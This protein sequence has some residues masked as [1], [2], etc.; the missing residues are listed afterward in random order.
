[1]QKPMAATAGRLCII[2]ARRGVWNIVALLLENGADVNAKTDDG[3]TPLV[4][5]ANS[6]HDAVGHQL[7]DNG[8]QMDLIA[9]V[10]FEN[11]EAVQQI[12]AS[13]A[14]VR[15]KD[16]EGRTI[17][18][19]VTGTR[20]GKKIAKLLLDNGAQINLQVAAWFNDFESARQL[21]ADGAD[22]RAKNFGGTNALA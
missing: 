7:I 4:A 22:V 16:S 12:I 15:M 8:A 18:D 2:A 1:M 20:T 17:L 19:H 10:Q 5:A 21:I 9:A 11:L 3:W 6:G 14:E 13:G